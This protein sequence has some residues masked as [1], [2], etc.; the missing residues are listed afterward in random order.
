MALVANN[1]T[2]KSSLLKIIANKD[3][4]SFG[5]VTVRKGIQI[6]YLSQNSDF[7]ESLTIQQLVDSSQTRVSEI[8]KKY[9]KAVGLQ[10][11]NFSQV[12]QKKV[13]ELTLLMDQYS[14]WD[15]DR[16]IKLIL[17]NFD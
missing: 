10:T 15:Y 9:E 16:G 11:E 6:G 14:A 2:G 4:A 13:E 3:A 5:K 17:S 7:D 8:I 12:N 1:G